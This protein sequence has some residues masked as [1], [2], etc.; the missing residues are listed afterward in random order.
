VLL[1]S[2]VGCD[3]S[4]SNLAVVSL[5]ADAQPTVDETMTCS[6]FTPYEVANMFKII[7]SH[8]QENAK[9]INDMKELLETKVDFDTPKPSKQA[10][11]SIIKTKTGFSF[12][13]L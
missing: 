1:C 5:E 3:F 8:Q 12:S 6:S 7:T 4:A 10:L 11:V 9:K 2:C 13:S